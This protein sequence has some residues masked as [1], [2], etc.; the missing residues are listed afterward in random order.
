MEFRCFFLSRHY[1]VL[2]E[3]V[4][5]SF[6]GVIVVFARAL[7]PLITHRPRYRETVRVSLHFRI[8]T[9]RFMQ[10]VFYTEYTQNCCTKRRAWTVFE[11]REAADSLQRNAKLTLNALFF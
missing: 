3:W 9:F 6:L 4:N 11:R 8:H 7:Q 5:E 1:S 2:M 10:F